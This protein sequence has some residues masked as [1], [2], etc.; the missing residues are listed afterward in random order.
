E[1]RFELDDPVAKYLPEFKGLRVHAG[2]GDETVDAKR[3]VTIR[4]LMR[5]TSGLTYGF[6]SSTPVDM[7]YRQAKVGESDETLADCVR[8]L[9]K[10]PLLYQPGT[11]FNYSFSTDVLARIVEETSGKPLDAFFQERIFKPLDMKDTGFFV[12]ADK[13]DRFATNYGPGDKGTLK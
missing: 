6:I 1:G 11:H 5:H 9:G 10:L 3:Q 7:L 12:P 4:D 13:L 8:K 2:K